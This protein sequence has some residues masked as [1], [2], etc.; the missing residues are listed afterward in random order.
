MEKKNALRF[1][2]LAKTIAKRERLRERN[3]Y[4]YQRE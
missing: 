4:L 2:S 3:V 1:S